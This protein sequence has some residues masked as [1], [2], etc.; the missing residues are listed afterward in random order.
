MTAIIVIA[1]SYAFV[2]ILRA[3][4]PSGHADFTERVCLGL[5]WPVEFGLS[6]PDGLRAWYSRVKGRS[7]T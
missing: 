7:T 5:L 4:Y 6:L 3:T 1:V 2:G